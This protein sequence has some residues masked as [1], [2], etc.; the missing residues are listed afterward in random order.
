[1]LCEYHRRRANLN[2]QR[3]HQRRKLR[4]FASERTNGTPQKDISWSVG[5]SS[6]SSVSASCES[7]SWSWMA[8]AASEELFNRNTSSFELEVEPSHK[9]MSGDLPLPDL[10]ILELLL[11]DNACN[12]LLSVTPQPASHF[13]FLHVDLIEA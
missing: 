8:F 2:Q 12:M 6:P 10:Q 3:V 1:K 11:S 4:E 7:T 5:S 13:D 9:P